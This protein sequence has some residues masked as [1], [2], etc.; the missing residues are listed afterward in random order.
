MPIMLDAGW[1]GAADGFAYWPGALEDARVLYSVHMY[2]PY[3]MTSDPTSLKRPALAYPGMAPFAGSQQHCDQER[4]AGY[5]GNFTHWAQQAR[6]PASRLVIGELGC[7][8]RWP[9]CARYLGDVLAVAERSAV[10]WAFYA[11]REDAWEGMDYELGSAPVRG[12]TGKPPKPASPIPSSAAA[13]RCS[14]SL[15]TT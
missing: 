3:R 5:L 11:F 2:E 4:V 9:D 10:H 1:Y 14:M 15:R 13:A 7:L 8:R 6:V 12:N